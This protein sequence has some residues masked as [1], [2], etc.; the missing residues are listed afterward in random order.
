MRRIFTLA[1]V[2]VLA[3]TLAAPVSAITDGD[4]DGDEHPMVGQLLFYVPTEIDDRFTDPG[5]WFTCTGTLLD[6]DTLLT[7]GHCTFGIGTGGTD[8]WVSFSEEPDFGILPPSASF[9]PDGLTRRVV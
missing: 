6:E 1:I 2:A 7:A 3:M 9:A 8:V 5:S 4:A